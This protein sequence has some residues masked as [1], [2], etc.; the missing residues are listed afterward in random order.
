MIVIEIP[1]IV[2][3]RKTENKMN[4]LQQQEEELRKRMEFRNRKQK[5][6]EKL[7]EYTLKDKGKEV[8]KLIVENLPKL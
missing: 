4:Y 5:E 6:L 8:K 3:R 2:T 7:K 1:L